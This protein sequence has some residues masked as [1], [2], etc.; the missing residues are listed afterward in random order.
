MGVNN[1]LLLL[2]FILY[3]ARILYVRVFYFQHEPRFV[4]NNNII[5][6]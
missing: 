1:V 6:Y 3:D 2:L 5:L 4:D